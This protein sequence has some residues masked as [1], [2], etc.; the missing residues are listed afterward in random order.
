MSEKTELSITI[1]NYNGG[2]NLKRAIES[3]RNIKMDEDRFRIK[4]LDNQSDDSSQE[5]VENLQEELDNLFL[6]K[7]TEN[8]GRIGNWNECIEEANGDYMIFLFVNEQI[9]PENNI[10]QI[11]NE[12]EKRKIPFCKSGNIPLSETPKKESKNGFK[13]ESVKGRLKRDILVD[14]SFSFGPLQTYVFRTEILKN[15]KV[16]FSEDYKI[17]GDQ[18]FV[19]R[20]GRELRRKNGEDYFLTTKSRNIIW[21]DETDRFNTQYNDSDDI[22]EN[23]R[24]YDDRGI[25]EYSGLSRK[26]LS[27]ARLSNMKIYTSL[28]YFSGGRFARKFDSSEIKEQEGAIY[29]LIAAVSLIYPLV[30]FKIAINLLKDIG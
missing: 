29:P 20:L 8:L 24:W 23:L 21:D 19:I 14:G 30:W 2:E 3:C 6:K 13:K 7:N 4:V 5:I 18:D 26:I 15:S 28:H 17:L 9:A 12:L 22:E 27:F 1:P 11:I 16:R 25:S 10:P